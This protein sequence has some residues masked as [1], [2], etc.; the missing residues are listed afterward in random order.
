MNATKKINLLDFLL[1]ITITFSITGYILAKAEKT[2]LNKIIQGKEKIAIDL[3]L[4]DVFLENNEIFKVGNETAITIRNRPY[5]KLS[6]IK[7]EIKPKQT[8]I[9]GYSNFSYKTIDDPTRTNVKD[10]FVTLTDT[11][12]KTNDGYVIGGNKIKIGNQIELEGFN[13]RLTGKVINIYPINE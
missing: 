4:P 5:T 6:I 1:V 13:Y 8:I 10:Y 9:P 11:A 12:L 2:P 7:I 3:L